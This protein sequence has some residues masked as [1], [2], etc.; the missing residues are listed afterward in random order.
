[1]LRRV[2]TAG[3]VGVA[4]AALGSTS[5]LAEPGP[6]TATKAP[7][8]ITKSAP[9]TTFATLKN[10]K[11]VP[12]AAK[13]LDAVKGQHVHFLDPGG[14]ELHLAGDVKTENNWE[15]IGGS[16]GKPVAPSYNGLCVAA[17][18]SGPSAGAILIPGGQFQCPL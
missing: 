18:Y 7:A 10:L 9:A 14:G 15:N 17:G 2:M 11:A 8:S 3:L 6:A 13:E 12:M 5:L 1:M 16:D 4:I